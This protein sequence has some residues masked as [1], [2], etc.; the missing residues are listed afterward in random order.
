MRSLLLSAV[1]FSFP[2]SI[3]AEDSP[4]LPDG[5]GEGRVIE[6]GHFRLHHEAP[7]APVGVT[8]M[9]EGLHAKLMLDLQEF[10]PWARSERIEVFV[11]ADADSY[12]RRTGIPAWSAAFAVPEK[13]QIHCYESP[14]LQRI[15]AHEMAHLFFM[16]YFD[17][18]AAEAPAW[19]IEGVAKVMEFSYGQAEETDFMNRRSF[20]RESAPLGKVFSFDYRHDPAT[21]PAVGFWYQQSASVTAYLMRRFPR[22]SFLAFCDALRRGADTDGALRQAYGAQIP[23]VAALERLWRSSL[24]EK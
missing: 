18:A 23:D 13:R 17:G 24:S 10:V 21:P 7:Y 19:L 8:G 5:F 6:T 15:L 4:S 11:Y 22:A 12:V 14:G 16:P 9:L 1:L 20:V 3:F 2:F